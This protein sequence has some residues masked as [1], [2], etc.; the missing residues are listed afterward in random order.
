MSIKIMSMIWED[1]PEGPTERFLLLALADIADDRGKCWPSVERIAQRCCMSERNARRILRK[2][3][4]TGWLETEVHPGRNRTNTYWI[5]KPDKLSA[6]TD[7]Q[8][9][10]SRPENR[11]NQTVKPDTAMSAKPSENH[12]EPSLFGDKAPKP[13]SRAM[14]LPDGWV[15]SQKNIEDAYNRGFSD[16]DIRSEAEAFRDYH[17]ARGTTFK[18]WNAAWRTWLGNA[19]KF[20]K[21]R[22]AGGRGGHD[23]LMA[24]FARYADSLDE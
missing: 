11:T 15:P 6:Q 4:E 1:G 3:E 16:A 17:L 24:G 23:A 22:P 13:R 2:L 5:R 20:A 18:D 14:A 7:C 9:G 21:A 12:Q 10:Q 8:P 19:R